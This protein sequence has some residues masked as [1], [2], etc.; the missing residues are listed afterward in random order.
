MSVG[1]WAVGEMLGEQV[2]WRVRDDLLSQVAEVGDTVYVRP[3][4]HIL[5]HNAIPLVRV[6]EFLGLAAEKVFF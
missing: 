5:E 6:Q 2:K 3:L 1:Y 4:V